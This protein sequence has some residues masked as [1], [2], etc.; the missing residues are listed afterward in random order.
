MRTFLLIFVHLFYQIITRLN[1]FDNEKEKNFKLVSEFTDKSHKSSRDL[2]RQIEENGKLLNEIN[3]LKDKLNTINMEK[4]ALQ[5]K[6]TK[7][8]N[9]LIINFINLTQKMHHLSTNK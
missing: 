9:F 7:E 1:R 5:K 6:L 3:E 4:D 8:V 2:E